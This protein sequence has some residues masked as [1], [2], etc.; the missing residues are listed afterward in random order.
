MDLITASWKSG[1]AAAFSCAV[2]VP[3]GTRMLYVSGTTG[4]RKD[5]S[6]PPTV[7]EQCATMWQNVLDLLAEQGLDHCCIVRITAYITRAEHLAAYQASRK[8]ALAG[9]LPASTSLIVSGFV[10]PD[11]LAELDVIAAFPA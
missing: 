3:A 6:V 2:A 7:E 8:R 9:H 5:G 11:L 1:Q 10:H 4:R